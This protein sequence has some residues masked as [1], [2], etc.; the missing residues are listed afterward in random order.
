MKIV[1]NVTGKVLSSLFS[2]FA[3]EKAFGLECNISFIANWYILFQTIWQ[4][5]V[6]RL[7]KFFRLY[8]GKGKTAYCAIFKL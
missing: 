3:V 6:M 4:L 1:S 5:Q 7:R 2:K 8:S